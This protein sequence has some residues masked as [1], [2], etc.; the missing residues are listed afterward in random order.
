MTT[1]TKI[2]IFIVAGIG[3]IASLFKM[4]ISVF[5]A[6]RK[7]QARDNEAATQERKATIQSARSLAYRRKNAKA[8]LR[9]G[10]RKSQGGYAV[11]ITA[12]P[13]FPFALL[14]LVAMLA[15]SSCA[16]KTIP[17]A[18]DTIC[19]LEPIWPDNAAIDCIDEAL[20][21]DLVAQNCAILVACDKQAYE[22]I[23]ENE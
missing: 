6:G 13:Q 5:G 20:A 7:A 11:A 1:L 9:R 15:L 17:V 23:C 3:I 10:L 21:Q 22:D 4:I 12:A 18:I 16:A 8:V 14:A 2:G 19:S